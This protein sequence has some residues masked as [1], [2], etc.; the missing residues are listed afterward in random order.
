MDT[1][2][3]V[4]ALAV[5]AM[6]VWASRTPPRSRITPPPVV[7]ADRPAAADAA[8]PAGRSPHLHGQPTVSTPEWDL[9]G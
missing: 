5:A 9:D 4:L 1:P 8:E 6:F 2:L 7:V 3:V